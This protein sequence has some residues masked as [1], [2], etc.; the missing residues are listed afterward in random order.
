[1]SAGK[2]VPTAGRQ[3][4]RQEVAEVLFSRKAHLS[5]WDLVCLSKSVGGKLERGVAKDWRNWALV[6]S[7]V[8]IRGWQSPRHKV[9]LVTGAELMFSFGRKGL[10]YQVV[11][12]CGC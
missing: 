3:G 12:H 11:I 10:G 7:E 2:K 1:M 5:A 9:A 6:W 4:I 8:V